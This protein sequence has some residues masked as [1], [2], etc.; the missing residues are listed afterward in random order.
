MGSA[1][2]AYAGSNQIGADGLVC[3]HN[4]ENVGDYANLGYAEVVTVS[5]PE[6]EFGDF[7]SLFWNLCPHGNRKDAMDLDHQYRSLVG[8]PGGMESPL[9]AQL[10]RGALAAQLVAGKGGEGDP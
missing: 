6:A 8:L 7:A 10:A 3:Y 9:V 1:R 5:V 4:L 2:T